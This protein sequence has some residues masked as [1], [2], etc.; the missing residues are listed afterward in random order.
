MELAS[1]VMITLAL[2]DD[3]AIGFRAEPKCIHYAVVA[4]SKEAPTLEAV[5][6]LT[7]PMTFKADESLAWYSK[8]IRALCVRHAAALGWVREAES[9]AKVKRD[10]VAERARIEGVIIAAAT[11][12]GLRVTLGRLVTI[13]AK[14]KPS[15][16]E[17]GKKK[18][19]KA[20][21]EDDCFLGID[22]SGYG[23]KQ[24]EAIMVGVVSLP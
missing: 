16:T 14:L 9:M 3:K 21:L 6:V 11:A 7:A 19:A 17:D 10:L 12:Q 2:R 23:N 22:W 5:D 15:F 18:H 20:Y 24:R 4:G 1:K 13:T 8:E